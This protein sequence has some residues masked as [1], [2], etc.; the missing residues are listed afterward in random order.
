MR[1]AFRFLE[2]GAELNDRQA[3]R[4]GRQPDGDLAFLRNF[5]KTLVEANAIYP[6]GPLVPQAAAAARRGLF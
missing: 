6:R 2:E 3:R 1:D 5:E 4:R